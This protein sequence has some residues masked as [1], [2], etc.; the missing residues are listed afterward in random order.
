MKKISFKSNKKNI[1]KFIL[2]INLKTQKPD[3]SFKKYE[4]HPW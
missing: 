3:K 1:F 4:K 2:N